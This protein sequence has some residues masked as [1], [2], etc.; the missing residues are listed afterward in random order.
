MKN[1]FE[2]HISVPKLDKDRSKVVQGALNAIGLPKVKYFQRV[3]DLQPITIGCANGHDIQN[4]GAMA[5][6]KVQTIEE[7][8]N[9]VRTGMSK[10]R[11]LG[12]GGM[13]FEIE[14]VMFPEDIQESFSLQETLP[15]F[16][17]VPNSPTYE[18][19]LL[20][21][22]TLNELPSDEKI[23]TRVKSLCGRTINQI[24]DFT[25]ERETNPSTIISRVATIYQPSHSAAAQM[26]TTMRNLLK[27]LGNPRVVTERVLL[28][29]EFK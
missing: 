27:E 26:D 3:R 15:D 14:K 21:K 20:F 2:V 28:V 6:V 8:V 22:G 18:N 24:V 10:L 1:I 19:H 5:T 13:N 23:I 17:E 29:G 7:T 11:E 4:P 12:I 16:Q 25:G 9:L